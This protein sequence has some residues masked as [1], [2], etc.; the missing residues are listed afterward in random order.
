MTEILKRQLDEGIITKVDAQSRCTHALGAVPKGD[1]GIRNIT[2]CSRPVG[3]SVNYHCTSLI[4]NLCFKSV[5][6]R[7][8]PTSSGRPK[9]SGDGQ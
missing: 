2:D 8:I 4:D 7:R 5:D 6:P 3:I 1:N 9:W